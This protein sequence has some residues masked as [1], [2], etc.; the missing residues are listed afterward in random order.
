MNGVYHYSESAHL[1]IEKACTPIRAFDLSGLQRRALNEGLL[2]NIVYLCAACLD[3]GDDYNEA[4]QRLSE[5]PY[6]IRGALLDNPEVI[7]MMQRFVRTA[8]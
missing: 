1:S 5:N 6:N 7:Q 8:Q 2:R 4:R 3:H